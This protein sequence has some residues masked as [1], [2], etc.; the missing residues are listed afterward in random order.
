M[1]IAAGVHLSAKKE[2]ENDL[3]IDDIFGCLIDFFIDFLLNFAIDFD[4]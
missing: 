2:Q 1:Y 4:G 3:N